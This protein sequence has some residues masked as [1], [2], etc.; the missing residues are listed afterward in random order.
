MSYGSGSYTKAEYASTLAATLAYFLFLQGDAVG[1]VAFDSQVR[2]FLPARHRAG[3]LRHI[4][5]ALEKPAAGRATDFSIPLR[6]VLE[7]VRKRGV[8]VVISDFLA[9]IAKLEQDLMAVAAC[10]HE[11]ITFQ[12]LDPSELG[13]DFDGAA[14]FEDLESGRSFFLDPGSARKQYLRNLEAHVSS[15]RSLC[16]RLGVA[17]Y[18]LSTARPLESAL[19]EF[20]RGRKQRQRFVRRELNRASAPKS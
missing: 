8:I 7:V 16:D 1:L 5:L 18:S 6:R 10:G 17:F 13:F 14:I 15:L 12:T 3:H 11:V 2:D 9:P 4:M 20:L 19:F